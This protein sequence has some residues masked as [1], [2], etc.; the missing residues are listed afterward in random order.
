MF[1]PNARFAYLLDLIFP[2]P[3]GK[4]AGGPERLRAVRLYDDSDFTDL[5][6]FHRLDGFM[7]E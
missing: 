6:L 5:P 2:Q 3:N 4:V 7:I 1:R